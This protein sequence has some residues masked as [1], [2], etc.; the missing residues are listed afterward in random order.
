MFGKF[1]I[2]NTEVLTPNASIIDTE[3]AEHSRVHNDNATVATVLVYGIIYF[4]LLAL[5]TQ[6]TPNCDYTVTIDHCFIGDNS[7]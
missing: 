7:I 5:R 4:N 6:F 3:F 2:N 1:S